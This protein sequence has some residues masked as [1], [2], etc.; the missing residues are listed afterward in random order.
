MAICQG[1][2]KISMRPTTGW[3]GADADGIGTHVLDR[4]VLR[5]DDS[6]ALM[7]EP[8]SVGLT[9]L[10]TIELAGDSFL[11]VATAGTDLDGCLDDKGRGGPVDVPGFLQSKLLVPREDW[12][13]SFL[14][15][16]SFGLGRSWQGL[17]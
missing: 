14:S 17:S 2:F 15:R 7:T 11:L 8:S 13:W 4:K 1:Y 10:Q 6:V 12:W 5:L 16:G 3:A 9:I